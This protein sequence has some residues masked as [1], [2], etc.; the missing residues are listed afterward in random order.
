MLSMLAVIVLAGCLPLFPAQSA[1]AAA[2]EYLM[3]MNRP[4]YASSMMGN[5]TPDLAVDGKADTRW[6]SVWKKDPQWIY[7][8]LGV[9]ASVSKV[10][11]SWE[12]AYST[13]YEIQVSDDE[14][15]WDTIYATKEGKGGN[16]EH[17]VS[18]EGRYVRLYST[19]RAQENYGVSIWE[20]NVYGTGGFNTQ[21]KP[22]A[23]DL[24]LK[25]PVVVSSIQKGEPWTDDLKEKDYLPANATDG[26]PNTR[27]SSR[28][29]DNEWIYV[30]LGA[31][32]EI[33]SVVFH[34][35]AAA[36]RAYDIQVSDDAKNWTTIYRQLKGSGGKEEIPLY[37]TGRYV[38]MSGIG[39]ASYHGYSLFAFEV[40]A[41]REGDLK[42]VYAIPAIP[43]IS[44]VHVGK[45]SYEI[46]DITQLEPK[47]PKYRTDNI[48]TPIPSNDWWQSILIAN[49]GDGNSLV[50]LPLK[51]KYTKLGLAV[52]NP[53]AG[54]ASSDGGSVNADGDP[55]LYLSTNTINPADVVTKISGYGDY[56]AS[57][58][59]SDDDSVKMETTFVKG[60]PY[61]YNTFENPDAVI[62]QSPV[63]ARLFDDHNNPVLENDGDVLVSD[64]IGIEV[65][66]TDRAPKP[67]SFVRHYGIFAPPG[68]KFVKLGNTIKLKFANGDNYLS[69]AAMT[70]A[71]DLNYY[72]QHA[73][74]FI[75][76]TKVDYSF[77]QE[78]S[79]VTTN[80]NTVTELKRPG[81]STNTLMTL[82]PHQWKLS[83]TPLTQRTYPSIRGTLKVREGNSFTTVDRF[84][85]I[86]PQ[87]VEPT[88]P[89][90]SRAKLVA[91]LDSLDADMSGQIMIAD[92][93]WQGKKLHPL[94]LGVLISDQLG[95][96][97]RSDHYL[98]ILKTI[99]SD[100]Y[101]FSPDEEKHSYYF[102]YSQDWGAIFPYSNGFGIN[103][104][105]TD[106]H[107]TYGYYA[108]ASAILATY[109][110]QFLSDYG[111]MVETLIRD[112]ANPSRTDSEYPWFRNFDPYEGH[113]WAGGYADNHSGNNQEA[114][115]EALFGWVGQYM[116]GV[117]TGNREYRDAAIWGF[118]TE[119][120][121]AEQYWFD[122][123]DD[124]FLPGYKHKSVGQVYGSS[125]V[126]GTFFS[127]A[128][129]MVYGIH[130]LPTA[131]WMTYYA[132]QPEKTAKVF[133]GLLKDLNG[134]PVTEWHHIMWPY[135]AL[136]D[137][138]QVIKN[139]NTSRMQQ[140]EVFN[141]Y[142]F[143][144]SMASLGSRSAEIWAN[145]PSVTV[146]KKG[147]QY[148]A[149][150]WNPTDS[151]KTIRFFNASGALGTATVHPHALVAVDP[152]IVTVTKPAETDSGMVY[153]DRS[154]WKITTS[155]LAG[156]SNVGNMTDDDLTTR[157][158]SGKLQDSSLWLEIDLNSEQAFDTIFMNSGTSY[159]DYARGYD[160]FVSQDGENWGEAVVSEK[161][162]STSL[163]V[164]LPMQHARFIRIALNT[165][166]DSWWSIA[167]LKIAKLGK[168]HAEPEVP[169]EP[170]GPGQ[171][172]QPGTP[173]G[174]ETPEHPG[175]PS[176][177]SNPSQPGGPSTP[178]QPLGDLDRSEWVVTASSTG[179]TDLTA[180][181]LDGNLGSRW[182]SGKDQ[183]NGMWVQVDL[184]RTYKIDAITIDPGHYTSDYGRGYNIYVSNDGQ[185]WGNAIAHGQGKPEGFT[186]VFPV[187][188][189][190]YVKIVQT[191]TASKWWSIAEL[192][193]GQYGLG[194]QKDLP[195]S[196]WNMTASSSAGDDKP[197]RML[198]GDKSTRWSTG[199]KQAAG[200]WIQMDLGANE[201]FNQIILDSTKSADDY[202]RE[203]EVYVS[204]DGQ[205]W[206][207]PVAAGK[208]KGAV[209]NIVFPLQTARYIKIVQT[210]EADKW[211][212][213]SGL[214]V[215]APD[216][217]NWIPEQG[218]PNLERSA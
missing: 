178:G 29:A 111:D 107:F 203:Y 54:Y 190:R 70:A 41:Y 75:K 40:H 150:I 194:K 162:S 175:N 35:E 21:P 88:N 18:G 168:D 180:N 143:V 45:G 28:Y 128:P 218:E 138:Q 177:P 33:G 154:A 182:N 160:V 97:K 52:L 58:I 212:S 63:M 137:P 95:D 179:G 129:E 135:Q 67:E 82:L 197:D 164:S 60:S 108:F 94:G 91:Y 176:G 171:P 170:E 213:I 99:L 48:K 78:S 193:I 209:T 106:H 155:A 110:K 145:D 113:S 32:S 181:M 61:L 16:V 173:E 115:G 211:W 206:A 123:D 199:Q 34:W 92:P 7:V 133:A 140:N 47:D 44:T 112:Y 76:D 215:L 26:D 43:E 90:Y 158:S 11:I 198:D 53:G 127:G 23:P 8:D 5:S 101:T 17:T 79:L 141:T 100:W 124:I 49:L 122:Y 24:A 153:L 184:G 148:T 15:N 144:H 22:P 167:E 83:D 117:V 202:A 142:W 31:S 55:D 195:R 104:G 1:N 205:S 109:D 189:A 191:G 80:F 186:A 121:A 114:A 93:Y 69:V 157:W 71:E 159:G 185:S 6:E 74:A 85:G 161:G 72:Y 139:W 87:F 9:K 210:G 208:G 151:S 119:E 126:F 102:H 207:N 216:T 12:N 10:T 98:S 118:T 20:F 146:Y 73:Y 57:V 42:P 131:E 165:S 217:D 4:V 125:Y 50:T 169:G 156:G 196:G 51:N 152:T 64:H 77:D 166:S 214:R 38:K 62:L 172:G 68:T 201:S 105:L 89:E 120:K 81:F 19:K 204:I 46:G 96:T 134:G 103:T 147:N 116:W 132:R 14:M 13:A 30:D 136:S 39:R 163:A 59:M 188:Q 183:T 149:Q 56:S 37:A 3:S 192:N 200:Q 84:N 86:V 27:W 174:P 2:E 130:W 25:K 66:N 36:G 65:V 187:K